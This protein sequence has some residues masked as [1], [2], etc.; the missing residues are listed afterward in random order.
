MKTLLKIMLTG[1]AVCGLI[2]GLQFLPSSKVRM[3][4]DR[5]DYSS[6]GFAF[7]DSN[8]DGSPVTWNT[9]KPI[10]ILVETVGMP[11][12]AD[13]EIAEAVDRLNNAS[14]LNL[15]YLG[16]VGGVHSQDW[17]EN[18]KLQY[19][20]QP[21]ILIGWTRG[22]ADMPTDET[23]GFALT[24]HTTQ[25][26]ESQISGSVITL[27]SKRLQRLR[28]GFPPGESRGAVYMHEIAHALGLDHVPNEN[29]LMHDF[30]NSYNGELTEGD[31]AGLNAVA[32]QMC[33]SS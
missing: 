13:G 5:V 31:I 16:T 3:S 20:D 11:T 7:V 30:V 15:N 24:T 10:D 19:P 17:V 29:Q 26:N 23:V 1:L 18:S 27:H 25:R 28:A 4:A 14:D 9:C 12:G 6:G 22:N 2:Y 8:E 33:P 21:P 32:A